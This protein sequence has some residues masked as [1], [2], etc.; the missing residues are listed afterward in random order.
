MKKRTALVSVILSFIPFGQPL[1]VKT[2]FV[3][4]TI[5]ISFSHAEKTF[6][7]PIDYPSFNSCSGYKYIGNQ[8]K[9]EP[10]KNGVKI[11]STQEVK[12]V[13]DFKEDV[14]K[15][16]SEADAKAKIEIYRFLSSE[17]NEI[18]KYDPQGNVISTQYIQKHLGKMSDQKNSMRRLNSIV[19]LAECYEPYKFVRVTFGIKPETIK[20]YEL[21]P[22]AGD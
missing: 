1:L 18:K 17:I 2:S 21:N 4:S 22:I 3:L 9:I 7:L 15:A 14:I 20:H 8:T 16:I 19:K 12:V 6:A 13:S 10:L 11:L 5:G